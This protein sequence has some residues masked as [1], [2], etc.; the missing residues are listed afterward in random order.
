MPS[1]LEET[2]L[3][4]KIRALVFG[5]ISR[6]DE[7]VE[8]FPSDQSSK[9]ITTTKVFL[10]QIELQ[11][12]DTNSV[13]LLRW[14]C[15]LIDELSEVLEWLDHAHTAQTPP[16]LRQHIDRDLGKSTRRRRDPSNTYSGVKL[17]NF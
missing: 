5:L 17:Q 11:L 2:Y 15:K 9:L 13:E 16:R 3:R 10:H 14:S 12:P 6:L 8:E 1:F 4:E 7:F